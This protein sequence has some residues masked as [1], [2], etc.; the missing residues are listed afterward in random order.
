MYEFRLITLTRS[1]LRGSRASSARKTET[2]SPAAR[3]FFSELFPSIFFSGLS[4]SHS[5]RRTDEEKEEETRERRSFPLDGFAAIPLSTPEIRVSP[6]PPSP[7][8]YPPSRITHFSFPPRCMPTTWLFFSGRFDINTLYSRTNTLP[9][10][11]TTHTH[12]HTNTRECI[13]P[14]YNPPVASPIQSASHPR[15]R[16]YIY[17]IVIYGI[18]NYFRE[19]VPEN[20]GRLH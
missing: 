10:C 16:L 20:A 19:R 9:V 15:S 13:T 1:S 8:V 4:S 3:D 7:L 6:P 2:R 18:A 5:H 11:Q 14:T 17:A 12:T